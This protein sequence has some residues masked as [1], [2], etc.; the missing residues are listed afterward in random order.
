MRILFL[1]TG[2]ILLTEGYLLSIIHEPFLSM[3]SYLLGGCLF[4]TTILGKF[5]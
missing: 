1:L 3:A 4:V 5:A 2:F